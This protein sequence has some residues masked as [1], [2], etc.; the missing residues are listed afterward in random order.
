[1]AWHGTAWHGTEIGSER[2]VVGMEC[3][4]GGGGVCVSVSVSFQERERERERAERKSSIRID[5]DICLF[6]FVTLE[7]CIYHKIQYDEVQ[8]FKSHPSYSE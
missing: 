7:S 5:S 3:V 1:M 6:V 8:Y 4:L 2:G